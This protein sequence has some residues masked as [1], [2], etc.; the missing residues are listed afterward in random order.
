MN[1]I[2]AANVVIVKRPTIEEAEDNDKTYIYPVTADS[3]SQKKK[4]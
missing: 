4:P 2:G 3:Q 1:N